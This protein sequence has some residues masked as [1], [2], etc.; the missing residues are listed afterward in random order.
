MNNTQKSADVLND[1]IQIN[2]DRV[3]GF[4]KALSDI[5]DENVDL[6]SLFQEYASQSRKYGQELTALVAAYGEDTNK[7][8]SFS[9]TLHRAWIDIKSLFGGNDRESILDEAERG[10]DA[11][12][13]AYADALREGELSP[14]ATSVVSRQADGIRGA[15]DQIK[16]LRDAA[17]VEA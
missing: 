5:K 8:T 12:K 13:K 3:E 17:H 2:N 7:G 9:G 1:L 10:E 15:H 16:A 14:D 11:I 4:E 6:K